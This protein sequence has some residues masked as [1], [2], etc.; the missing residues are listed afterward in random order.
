MGNVFKYRKRTAV[1]GLAADLA[2]DA[3]PAPDD[4]AGSVLIHRNVLLIMPSQGLHW[5][6]CA[7]LSFGLSLHAERLSALR[8][9]GIAIKVC[10]YSYPLSDYR[11]EVAALTM[12]GWLR[13]EFGLPDIGIRVDF[14]PATSD[15]SF[16]WGQVGRPFSEQ[17]I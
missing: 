5:L 9:D 14:T 11:P 3:I 12:D 10:S 4:R 2:A 6:D 16:K 13:Q 17:I 1:G 8:P 15:Y 7:W